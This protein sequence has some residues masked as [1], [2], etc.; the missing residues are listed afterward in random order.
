MAHE[1]VERMVKDR[2][3]YL[4]VAEDHAD[5]ANIKLLIDRQRVMTTYILQSASGKSDAD[6]FVESSYTPLQNI[7][8]AAMVA[9]YLVKNKIIT[10][11]AGTASGSAGGPRVI[12]RV[13]ADVVETEFMQV[14]STDGTILTMETDKY[15]SELQKEI[16]QLSGAIGWAN[17]LC[18]KRIHDIIPP[19]AVGADYPPYPPDPYSGDI[20]KGEVIGGG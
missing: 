13:K 9:Y 11:L 5:S 4:D 12:K 6:V 19:F 20:W 14:K 16:C 2:V 7:L 17:P 10:N 15:L 1:S 3:P 18:G 8:F